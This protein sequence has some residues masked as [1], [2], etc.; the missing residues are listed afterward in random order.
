MKKNLYNDLIAIKNSQM[1]KKG[2][3]LLKRTRILI[4]F[5]NLLWNEGYILGYKSSQKLVKIFLKYNNCNPV[6]RSL[7][8][9]S[10]SSKKRYYSVQQIWKINSNEGFFVISTSKGFKSLLS[11]KKE[12]IG[13]EPFIIIG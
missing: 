7:T 8:L 11:C 5:L 3:V 1:T 12:N 4:S 9:L 10:K 6:I 13:G 2:F